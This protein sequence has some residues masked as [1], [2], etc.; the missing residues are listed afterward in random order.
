MRSAQS[1]ISRLRTIE[2]LR[3]KRAQLQATKE[4]VLGG[5][6]LDTSR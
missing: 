2:H 3:A 1:A 6:E 5:I 4:V